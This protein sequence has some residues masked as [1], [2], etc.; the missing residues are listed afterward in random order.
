MATYE[1]LRIATRTTPD[2]VVLELDGELD[3]VNSPLL[4]DACAGSDVAG[5][6]TLVL[7]LRR[8]S[9]IDSTGLKAI[10]SARNESRRRGQQFAVT[11]GSQ[12]VERLLSVTRLGEHLRTIATP[13][14]LLV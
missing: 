5:S 3:M 14:E 9:F 6:A 12:Q 11:P 1:Q 4:R 10:F 8:L 2:R 7:D 13:D